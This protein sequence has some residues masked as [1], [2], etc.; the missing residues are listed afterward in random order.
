MLRGYYLVVNINSHFL[1]SVYLFVL[2]IHGKVP[3][4]MFLGNHDSHQ[5]ICLTILSYLLLLFIAACAAASLAIGTRN[6]EQDT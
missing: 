5:V 1:E 4:D 3:I 2:R 6:G